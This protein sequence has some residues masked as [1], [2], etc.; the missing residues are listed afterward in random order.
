MYGNAIPVMHESLWT[1]TTPWRLHMPLHKCLGV[2]A[3]NTNVKATSGVAMPVAAMAAVASIV[4][5][6]VATTKQTVNLAAAMVTAIFYG[7]V[8]MATH[9]PA[10]FGVQPG[11]FL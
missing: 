9:T 4:P 1:C 11:A 7:G 10:P 3:S 8:N 5:V 2:C 6:V